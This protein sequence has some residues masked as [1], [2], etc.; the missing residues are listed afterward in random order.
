LERLLESVKNR[1]IICRVTSMRNQRSAS[2]SVHE[3]KEIVNCLIDG[4]SCRAE[5]MV[6]L[7]VARAGQRLLNQLQAADID[8]TEPIF[9]FYQIFTQD[10]GH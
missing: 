7:H 9:K 6:R 1:A 4:D 5:H 10:G 8:E 2:V 3:H